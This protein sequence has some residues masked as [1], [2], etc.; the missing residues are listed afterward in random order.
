MVNDSERAN[1]KMK[2]V[3]VDGQPKLCLFAIK[4]IEKDTEL[5][6]DYGVKDLPWRKYVSKYLVYSFT[7]IC[8]AN[9]H[10]SSV[11]LF[12]SPCIVQGLDELGQE[13]KSHFINFSPLEIEHLLR[14]FIL[15][16]LLCAEGILQLSEAVLKF[17]M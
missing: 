1:C 6:F 4:P 2:V 9:T 5:R 13:G 10:S 11:N 12:T 17:V 7:L 8:V 15:N 14:T 3:V 16:Y